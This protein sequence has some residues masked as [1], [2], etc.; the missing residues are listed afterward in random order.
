MQTKKVTLIIENPKP[1]NTGAILPNNLV[2]PRPEYCPMANSIKNN[3]KPA[4]SNIIT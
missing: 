4:S 1:L 2:G 3:G